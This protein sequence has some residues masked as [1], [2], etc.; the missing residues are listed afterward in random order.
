MP[1]NEIEIVTLERDVTTLPKMCRANYEKNIH[2][3][4]LKTKKNNKHMRKF[5]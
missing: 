5:L 4:K 3:K 1:T 2:Q